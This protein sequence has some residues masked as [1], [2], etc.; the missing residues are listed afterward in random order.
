MAKTSRRSARLGQLDILDSSIGAWWRWLPASEARES[1]MT[2]SGQRPRNVSDLCQLDLGG[3][4]LD[5]L[6]FWGH[7]PCRDG[8]IGSGCLSQWWP[9]PFIVDGTVYPTAEHF[10]MVSKA[11]LFGDEPMAR[12]V[13]VAPSPGAAKMLGRAIRGYDEE[14]WA[15][16]RYGV[17]VEGNVA[18]FD[19]NPPLRA[20]LISTAGR[21]LVEASPEDRVW[22]IGMAASD[23]RAGRPSR[24]RGLNLLGFALMDVRERLGAVQ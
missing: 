4:R 11:R 12:R 17:V 6:F 10:M 16:S 18:K 13:L 9:A 5:F 19:Q 14:I 8:F 7:R 22:G 23:G 15:A 3:Q 1:R 2:D 20:Y 21:I 24:W